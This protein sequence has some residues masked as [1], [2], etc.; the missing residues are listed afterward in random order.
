M[1]LTATLPSR[2]RILEP[3]LPEV[4][5]RKIRLTGYVALVGRYKPLPGI[6]RSLLLHFFTIYPGRVFF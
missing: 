5:V 3:F 6:G 4:R 1:N 2:R